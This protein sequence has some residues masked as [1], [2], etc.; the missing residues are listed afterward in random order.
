MSDFF[1][2]KRNFIF[3][4]TFHNK[5][6]SKPISFKFQKPVDPFEDFPPV[7]IDENSNSVGSTF[8]G[9]QILDILENKSDD[10]ISIV[11]YTAPVFD[12]ILLCDDES[13]DDEETET[14]EQ[15]TETEEQETETEVHT[16][17]QQETEQ[18]PEPELEE[19]KDEEDV[20]PAR[21]KRVVVPRP[22]SRLV[23]IGPN[24]RV[25]LMRNR[26]L[27]LQ[28]KFP[29]FDIFGF[30][31]IDHYWSDRRL[32]ICNEERCTEPGCIAFARIHVCHCG[33]RRMC[34]EH[35]LYNYVISW[36]VNQCG[37]CRGNRDK[38]YAPIYKAKIKEFDIN[39]SPSVRAFA[40]IKKSLQ[41]LMSRKE[42]KST[43]SQFRQISGLIGFYF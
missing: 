8:N 21:K 41:S 25:H 12:P 28:E 26:R 14:E 20:R 15:E 2:R 43:E 1:S 6:G 40:Q 27:Q 29:G 30:E 24:A 33:T 39:T 11:W 31:I 5:L 23:G 18:P 22:P 19:Q 7:D 13:I 10:N 36:F 32:A 9:C 35:A 17:K 42:R 34:A 4:E 3:D 16:P 37:D 38:L